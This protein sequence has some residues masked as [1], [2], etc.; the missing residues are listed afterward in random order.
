MTTSWDPEKYKDEYRTQLMAVIE[1]KVK[2]PHQKHAA[3]KAKKTPSNVIDLMSVLQESLAHTKAA[4]GRSS[5]A[6]T[7]AAPGRS[8]RAKTKAAKTRHRK[9]A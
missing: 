5:R 8:S 2:H 9:A 4:P 1:E 3:P 6:Q 7:K